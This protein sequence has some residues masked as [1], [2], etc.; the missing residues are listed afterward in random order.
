MT[1]AG[2]GDDEVVKINLVNIPNNV[3]SIWAVINV[4]TNG[5]LFDDVSG[6]YCRLFVL[7]G[8]ENKQIAG[9]EFCKFNLS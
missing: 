5:K 1:G 8:D 6:A 2:D 9:S 4:Y 7:P 3:L